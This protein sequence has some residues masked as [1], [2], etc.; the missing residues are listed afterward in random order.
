MH[1]CTTLQ[2]TDD[3]I[4]DASIDSLITSGFQGSLWIKPKSPNTPTHGADQFKSGACISPMH[5]WLHVVESVCSFLANAPFLDGAVIMQ[6]AQ[7]FVNL[8]HAQPV[9]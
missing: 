7:C 4:T 8:L 5:V 2:F 9:C 6:L 1:Y 3:I